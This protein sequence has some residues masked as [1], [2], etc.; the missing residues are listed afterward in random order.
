VKLKLAFRIVVSECI[1]NILW[2]GIYM[3]FPGSVPCTFQQSHFILAYGQDVEPV[4]AFK[5]REERFGVESV[6]HDYQLIKSEG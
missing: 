1:G 4:V 5:E 6:C 2:D 3:T